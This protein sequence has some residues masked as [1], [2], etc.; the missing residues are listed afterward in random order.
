MTPQSPT[1]HP[2]EQ[3]QRIAQHPHDQQG[4]LDYFQMPQLLLG[5]LEKDWAAVPPNP[6]H[7]QVRATQTLTPH[8]QEQWQRI[9]QHP[10]DQGVLPRHFKVPPRTPGN[11]ERVSVVG[12]PLKLLQLV[13]AIPLLT[14]HQAERWQL[15]VQHPHDQGQETVSQV[16]LGQVLE[17][18]E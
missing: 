13:V 18:G 11:L 10:H 16:V 8:P 2:Q 6:Q 1:L 7:L 12:V 4:F 5:K 3:W 17:E 9:V 14:L 15:I